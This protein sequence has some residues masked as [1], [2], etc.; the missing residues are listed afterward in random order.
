[1]PLRLTEEH[2]MSLIQPH[3]NPGEQILYK[4]HGIEQPW[5][6]HLIRIG[7][8]FWKY[9]I[10]V[11]TNQRLMLIQVSSLW[12]EK[13]FESVDWRDLERCEVKWGL[14]MKPL[15]VAAPALKWKH[16]IN[17]PRFSVLKGNLES[18]LGIV[19]TWQKTKALPPAASSAAG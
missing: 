8:F 15:V 4:G 18:A 2:A 17:M 1:M 19:D 7:A 9:F 5:W 11:G 14:L 3:L 12:K 10:V 16:K 6:T 13:A